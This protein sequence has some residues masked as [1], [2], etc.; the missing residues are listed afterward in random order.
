VHH[1]T[2]LLHLKPVVGLPHLA[3]KIRTAPFHKNNNSLTCIED[4]YMMMGS[5][6]N[7]PQANAGAFNEYFHSLVEKI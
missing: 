2:R 6:L 5:P 4:V 1:R 3:L 7:N